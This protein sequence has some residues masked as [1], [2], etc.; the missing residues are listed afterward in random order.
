MSG[1]AALVDYNRYLVASLEACDGEKQFIINKLDDVAT[2][3]SK[4]G[5]LRDE[6]RLKERTIFQLQH[7]LSEHR[8]ML[9]EERE[10]V[11]RLINENAVLQ[12]QA[13]D[14]RSNF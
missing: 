2:A 6:L 4:L 5:D 14:D 9:Q 13:E 1:D 8:L 3:Q 11:A 7:D 12:A 10:K